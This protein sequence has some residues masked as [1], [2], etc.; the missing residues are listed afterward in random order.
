M[1][2]LTRRMGDYD[3]GQ[4]AK[5]VGQNVIDVREKLLGKTIVN[6]DF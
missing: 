6:F 3:F 2:D 1:S 5:E 4:T